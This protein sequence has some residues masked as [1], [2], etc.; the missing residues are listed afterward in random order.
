MAKKNG[1]R[2]DIN[3]G[4]Y[5]ER[6]IVIDKAGVPWVID[7]ESGTLALAVIVTEDDKQSAVKPKKRK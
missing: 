5:R 7:P 4:V 6:C 2:I 1:L 3:A